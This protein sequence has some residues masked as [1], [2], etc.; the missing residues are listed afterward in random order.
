MLL[1]IIK[2]CKNYIYIFFITGDLSNIMQNQNMAKL[3]YQFVNISVNQPR[4]Q[5]PSLTYLVHPE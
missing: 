2:N 5:Q 4:I 3:S 1:A